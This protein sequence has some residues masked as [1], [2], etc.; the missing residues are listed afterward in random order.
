MLI[1]AMWFLLLDFWYGN[2]LVVVSEGGHPLVQMMLGVPHCSFSDKL[3][4]EFIPSQLFFLFLGVPGAAKS[5]TPSYRSTP[6]STLHHQHSS[7]TRGAAVCNWEKTSKVTKSHLS[8]I[9]WDHRMQR[10]TL[11]PHHAATIDT[12]HYTR[13]CVWRIIW[14]NVSAG[15]YLALTLKFSSSSP[16]FS[17]HVLYFTTGCSFNEEWIPLSSR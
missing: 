8:A 17:L 13:S 10:L 16:R 4:F 6:C 3:Y 9:A 11:F 14:T 7:N 2:R 5:P 15:T 1:C 12:V